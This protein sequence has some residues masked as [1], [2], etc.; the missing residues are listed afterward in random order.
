M[1]LCRRCGGKLERLLLLKGLPPIWVT[2][3]CV[4]AEIAAQ[5]RKSTDELPSVDPAAVRDQGDLL[6]GDGRSAPH[7]TE[8][9]P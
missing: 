7:D 9:A 3:G 6:G 5:R 8:G 1:S 4:G 2:C